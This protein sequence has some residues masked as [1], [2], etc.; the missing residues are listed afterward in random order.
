MRELARAGVRL[1]MAP[2]M[3]H[4]KAVVVDEHMAMVGSVNL[5]SRSL[6]LNFELMTAFYEPADIARF[7]QWVEARVAGAQRYR[8]DSPSLARHVGEGLVLWLAFQL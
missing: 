1:W 3:L 4:G 5:D 7:A 2:A 6:F 8:P